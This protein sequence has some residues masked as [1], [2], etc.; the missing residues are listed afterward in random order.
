MAGNKQR[1]TGIEI[2]HLPV[3]LS[4]S[5]KARLAW[6]TNENEVCL[7]T[8]IEPRFE[9]ETKVIWKWP[10]FSTFTSRPEH[11]RSRKFDRDQ[12]SLSNEYLNKLLVL[13]GGNKLAGIKQMINLV[14]RLSVLYLPWHFLQRPREAE[15]RDPGNEVE[16]KVVSFS[17]EIC[18]LT[19]LKLKSVLWTFQNEVQQ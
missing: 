1:T 3:A 2:Q 18:I 13:D 12:S 7:W 16:W 15:R 14:P 8:S 9:K 5:I 17:G 10:G 11:K 6:C 19:I 4:L